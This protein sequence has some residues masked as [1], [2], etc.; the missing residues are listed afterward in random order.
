MRQLTIP[1]LELLAAQ[2]A[3][4]L[5]KQLKEAFRFPISTVH[6][7]VDSTTVLHWLHS[8]RTRYSTYVASRKEEI[9]EIT[10][11]DQWR[12][13]PG[14]INPADPGSRGVNGPEFG[15]EHPWLQGPDF[16]RKT[17]ESWPRM[18][19]DLMPI[20]SE[21]ELVEQVSCASVTEPQHELIEEMIAEA[22]D[23]VSLKRT[24]AGT[25]TTSPV[26]TTDDLQNAM[27]E[28]IRFA[29]SG[30]FQRDV[31]S[32]KRGG[33]IARDSR[34]RS[35]TPFMD[36]DGL[37]RVGGRIENSTLDHDAVHPI[38]LPPDGNLTRLIV[39]EAHQRLLHAQTERI[40]CEVR[41]SI[42]IL[43]GRQTV[44]RILKRCEECKRRLKR[45][46]QPMMAPLPSAR[47]VPFLPPFTNVGLDPFGPLYIKHGRGRIKVWVVLFTCLNTRAVH[48]ELVE[49]MDRD[50]F[51]LAYRRFIGRCSANPREVWSDNGTNLVAGAREIRAG[52][53]GLMTDPELAAYMADRSVKWHFSPPYAPNFGGV[54]ERL[55]GSAKR[56]MEAVLWNALVTRDVMETVLVEVTS[57]MNGRPLTHLSMDP[58]DE[59]PLTPNHFLT[60]RPSPQFPP[61]RIE[62]SHQLSVKRWRLA[63][64]LSSK[65]W[66]R[67]IREYIPTLIQRVKW[68]REGQSLSVGD[69]VLI[70]DPTSPRGVWP[71]GRVSELYPGADG[72][73]RTVLVTTARGACKRAVSGL[74][75]LSE[76]TTSEEDGS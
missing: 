13:C 29:Q 63:Q 59:G 23:L 60:G 3:A 28:C 31:H 73:V 64:E 6:F 8:E 67:W 10:T 70:V 61:Y 26:P 54:W 42:W 30:A 75:K 53:S 37:L 50:S 65:Y 43:R 12:Y 76:V 38:L 19:E 25:F 39:I 55:V 74:C 69:R 14:D 48:L 15:V 17:E 1:R 47:L 62:E 41:Q 34:L 49:G 66:R 45:P 56:A 9:L 36:P 7:W 20:K 2:E 32:L 51:L 57:M 5:W 18:P 4:L 24:V 35:F 58:K 22:A 27:K 21:L 16:L 33:Q 72:R 40:L 68:D 71:V 11:A 46:S 44:R 52:F